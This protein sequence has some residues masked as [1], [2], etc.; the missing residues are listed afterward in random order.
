M[1][2][3]PRAPI[4]FS[5]AVGLFICFLYCAYASINSSTKVQNPTDEQLRSMIEEAKK[6]YRSK[7]R[8]IERQVNELFGINFLEYKQNFHSQ[9]EQVNLKMS[10][11]EKIQDP[12]EKEQRN[13]KLGKEY[14][15]SDLFQYFQA[16]YYLQNELVKDHVFVGKYLSMLEEVVELVIQ[17]DPLFHYV[18]LS[19][20]YR[21][22]Q[23]EIAEI[24]DF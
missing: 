21:A 20:G 1:K 16:Y 19:K 15:N 7:Y 2:S 3:F 5:L 9:I 4:I 10:L 17:K 6:L 24:F 8:A 18:F 23:G 13:S 12:K 11:I 22:K 14:G